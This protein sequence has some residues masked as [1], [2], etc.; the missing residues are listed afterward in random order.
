MPHI[1]RKR[2]Q[3]LSVQNAVSFA[4]LF[5]KEIPSQNMVHILLLVTSIHHITD[6]RIFSRKTKLSTKRFNHIIYSIFLFVQHSFVISE[7]FLVHTATT[8]NVKTCKAPV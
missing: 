7:C 4:P 5:L 2:L 3:Q 1:G 8:A 6:Q